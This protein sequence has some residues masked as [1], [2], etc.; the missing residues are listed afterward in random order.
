MKNFF[1]KLYRLQLL[2]RCILRFVCFGKAN[3]IRK[4]LSKIIIVPSGKLGDVVC[5]SPVFLA[6]RANLPNTKI[7]VAGNTKL[8]KPL[9]SDSGLVD[10]YINLEEKGALKKIKKLKADVALITGPSFVPTAFLYLA[11]ISLVIAPKVIGGFSPN[12]TRPYKILQKFIK[13]F[14]YEIGKYAPKERL[15]SIE[16]LG[17]FTNNTKKHLGFSKIADKKIEQFFANNKIDLKKDF[18][19]GISPSAG[20]KIKEW[21]EERFAEIVDYLIERYKARVILESNDKQ[22]VLNVFKNIKNQDKV[23]NT[24]GKFNIDELKAF[25]SKLN[26]FISVDT[27]PIYIAEAFGVP[28]IDIV[29]PMDE[30][31]QPPIGKFHRVVVPKRNKPELHIMN[32]RAY[33]KKEARRQVFSINVFDVKKEIDEMIKDL[34]R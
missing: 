12:E 32:A 24:Q 19:V 26:L 30:K 7:I 28:T 6:L 29:G 11:G 21:P 17:I 20:N 4:D 34:R 14:E 16:P 27:G 2:V 18:V 10:D 31:E 8:H 13:T 3:K 23:I 25:V 15:K 5:C 1:E 9:L 33:N 22:K